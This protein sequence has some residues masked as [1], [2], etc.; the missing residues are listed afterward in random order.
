MSL[1]NNKFIIPE[2]IYAWPAENDTNGNIEYKRYLIDVS[3]SKLQK[4]GTQIKWRMCQ[5]YELYETYEAYYVIGIN[6]NGSFAKINK[7]QIAETINNLDK[8]C[9]LIKCSITSI[10]Y[11]N[12]ENGQIALLNIK[13]DENYNIKCYLEK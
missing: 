5:G 8:A 11:F 6:D 12:L 1:V 4:L 3:E 2:N 9:K 7:T 13:P 10:S